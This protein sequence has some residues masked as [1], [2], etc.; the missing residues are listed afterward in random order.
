[1][2]VKVLPMLLA[3]RAGIVDE[4]G[5]FLLLGGGEDQ[6]W[7]G[8]GILWLVLANGREVTR[9]TYDGLSRTHC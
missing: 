4:F 3:V 1:M 8:R 9:I 5:V 7:V 2:L 6:G